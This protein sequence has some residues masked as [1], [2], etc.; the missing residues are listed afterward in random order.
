MTQCMYQ[1][2]CGGLIKRDMISKG[3]L[4]GFPCVFVTFYA[5]TGILWFDKPNSYAKEITEVTFSI[6]VKT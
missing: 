4:I 5:F 1:N 6:I 2:K 3:G